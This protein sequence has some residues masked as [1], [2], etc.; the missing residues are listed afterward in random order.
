M[1]R[2]EKHVVRAI[3]TAKLSTQRHRH[4]VVI[5]NG[6][7]VLSVGVNTRRSHPSVCSDPQTESSFHAEVA[8]IRGLRT[9]VRADRMTVY[10]ARVD[11]YGMPQWSEPCDNCKVAMRREGITKCVFTT[12]KGDVY[13]W[14]PL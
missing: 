7:R 3:E 11:A 5:A 1:G 10:L 13:Q 4:G 8:A 14:C 6:N 9:T 2:I 12:G